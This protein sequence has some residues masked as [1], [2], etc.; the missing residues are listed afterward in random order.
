MTIA[1]AHDLARILPLC[2]LRRMKVASVAMA[3]VLVQL[4]AC[5][6]APP[7]GTGRVEYQFNGGPVSDAKVKVGNGSIVTTGAEGRFSVEAGGGPYDVTAVSADGRT[8]AV[9]VGLRRTDPTVLLPLEGPGSSVL[10]HSA[11]VT[12]RF[13]AGVGVPIPAGHSASAFF[14]APATAAVRTANISL[15]L[16]GTHTIPLNWRGDSNL[17]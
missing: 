4:T 16:D 13:L 11:L 14:T 2:Y 5:G 10:I 15:N 12:G 1:R 17:P 9:Y 6:D 8:A 7:R 3:A